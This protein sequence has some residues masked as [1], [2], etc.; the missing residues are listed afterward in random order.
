MQ[1]DGEP[2]MQTPCTVSHE[3]YLPY[4]NMRLQNIG[5]NQLKGLELIFSTA[6]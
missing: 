5:V 2:W 4:N 6:V 3:M 1:I